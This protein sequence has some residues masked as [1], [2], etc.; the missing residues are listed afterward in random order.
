MKT[1]GMPKSYS[2][3]LEKGQVYVYKCKECGQLTLQK[4]LV[5]K[6]CQGF[7]LLLTVADK[8]KAASMV[9]LGEEKKAKVQKP[10][11]KIKKVELE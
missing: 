5:C 4:K 1:Y 8:V 3:K 2:I 9:I 6:K 10:T 7:N 11:I